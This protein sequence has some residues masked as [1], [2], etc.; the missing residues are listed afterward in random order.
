MFHPLIGV[1]LATGG[2]YRKSRPPFSVE[3]DNIVF[4]PRALEYPQSEDWLGGN[5]W[6]LFTTTAASDHLCSYSS[7]SFRRS[8]KS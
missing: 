1:R 6:A 5:L 3:Y 2:M 7:R 8:T 4:L